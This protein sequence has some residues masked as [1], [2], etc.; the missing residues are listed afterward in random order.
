MPVETTEVPLGTLQKSKGGTRFVPDINVPIRCPHCNDL[1]DPTF[2]I[3]KKCPR[4]NKKMR[5]KDWAK[6]AAEALQVKSQGGWS[7][8]TL[9]RFEDEQ[10]G[11]SAY[12]APDKTTNKQNEKARNM[13][14]WAIQQKRRAEKLKKIKTWGGSG[15]S[16]LLCKNPYR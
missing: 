7:R 14:K 3:E 9:E 5:K 1:M 13:A 4:C 8:D 12:I 15:I 16:N 11:N 6:A 2:S 10:T